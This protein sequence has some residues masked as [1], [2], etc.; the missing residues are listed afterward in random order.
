MGLIIQWSQGE[1]LLGDGESCIIGRDPHADVVINDTKCSRHHLRVQLENG[2]WIASDLGSSNG[3]FLDGKQFEKIE[4][5]GHAAISLG[6]ASLNTLNLQVVGGKNFSAAPGSSSQVDASNQTTFSQRPS[7]ISNDSSNLHTTKTSSRRMTLSDRFQIGR[8]KENDLFINDLSVSRY[9]SEIV[10]NANGGHDLVDLNS[11]NGTYLNGKR[12]RRQGLKHGDLISIGNTTTRYVGTAI[13]PLG[14]SGGYSFEAK[15]ISVLIN[16]KKLLDNV[17]FS[18]N[19]RSLTAVIGP[20]GAG[21]ST[22]LNALTGRRL[23]TSGQVLIGDRAFYEN[24]H[25]FSTQIGLVPQQDLLHS[26]LTTKRALEYGASLRF[27]KDTTGPERFLRVDQVLDDL[28]LTERSS[29][30]IDKLSGGQR[31]RTS[32]ALELLTQP[33]LL[34]LDEPTSGLDPGLD[35]QVMNLL[36]DLA[37]DGRTVFVVTHSV[38]NLELC[39]NL[40]LMAPG[41]VVA[42]FGSPKSAL[43]SFGVKDWSEVFDLMNDPNSKFWGEKRFGTRTTSALMSGSKLNKTENAS[44]VGQRRKQ[45]WSFQCRTLIKRY[46]EVIR[47]DI[48]YSTFL[49]ALPFLLSIVGYVA[50]D[51]SGLV[52]VAENLTVNLPPNPKAQTLLLV[53]ILGTIFMGIS[54]SI[55]EVVKETVIFEREANVGLSQSAYIVSK[56]VV[57]GLITTIQTVLYTT[58]TLAGRPIP[59]E[60]VRAFSPRLEVLV[61]LSLL[62]IVSMSL[63]LAISSWINSNDVAM[64]AMVAATVSQIILSG[65]VPLRFEGILDSIGIFNPAYW[66]MNALASTSDLGYLISDSSNERWSSTASNW[67]QNIAMLL[68]FFIVLFVLTNVGLRNRRKKVRG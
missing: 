62:A 37:D 8:E 6:G 17:S 13:E 34:F 60:V 21:K 33:S 40:L 63:G 54:T 49:I 32:V 67:N 14:T 5:S 52:A 27:S 53:L 41:G 58:L 7:V 3:S 29:L 28:G 20:S 2:I 46:F 15:N 56:Y 64:P 35:R 30:R 59:E 57:L 23:P 26:G 18:V 68:V 42:Y 55:Q 22:L 4:I 25:E 66:A 48:Q 19:P 38:A 45:S 44:D 65:A 1:F 9:H 11:S 10:T 36:R 61:A 47:S 16:E 31:K 43:A 39:D 24:I 51:S 12:I 50:G